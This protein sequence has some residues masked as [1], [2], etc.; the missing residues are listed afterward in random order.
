MRVSESSRMVLVL[1]MV[2]IFHAVVYAS[3]GQKS[4]WQQLQ[5][6]DKALMRLRDLQIHAE[7]TLKTKHSMRDRAL[8]LQI[9][10]EGSE[11]QIKLL[12]EE[13]SAQKKILKDRV[14]AQMKVTFWSEFHLPSITASSVIVEAAQILAQRMTKQSDRTLQ[15]LER[16]NRELEKQMIELKIQTEAS[17]KISQ[18]LDHR[19]IDLQKN[20]QEQ[21]ELMSRLSRENLSSEYLAQ[22][23]ISK[24]DLQGYSESLLKRMGELS[25][26]TQGVVQRPYGNLVNPNPRYWLSHPGVFIESLPSASVYAVHSGRVEFVGPVKGMGW[27][28]I[29]NHGL[30]LRTVYSELSQVRVSEGSLVRAKQILGT[31]GYSDTH[32]MS[33]VYFEIRYLAETLNPKPWIRKSVGI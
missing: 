18:E 12:K 23:Q 16:K 6:R 4:I 31:S 25:L 17:T 26:P 9:Q 27:T 22:F 3:A 13:I 10:I 1:G 28:V 7:Q 32:L 24:Q 19:E 5:N 33:G 30:H 15:G 2:S 11:V 8:A 14:R 20:L 29:V 21:S